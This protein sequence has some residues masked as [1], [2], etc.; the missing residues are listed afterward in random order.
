MLQE[1]GARNVIITLGEHGSVCF[2]E[3]GETLTLPAFP[4]TEVDSNGAGDSFNAAFCVGLAEG[5][6]VDRAMLF[7]AA[8]SS[9][10]CT[11][12]ETVPSYHDR[13]AVEEFMANATVQA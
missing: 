8:T 4:I 11:Q 12:W 1:R 7:A 5:R 3:K 13:N 10:C 9:L 2:L 6:S